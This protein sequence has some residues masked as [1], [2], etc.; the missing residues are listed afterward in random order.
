M[1]IGIIGSGSIARRYIDILKKGFNFEVFVI[2]DQQQDKIMQQEIFG[3]LASESILNE[4]KI[5]I[6]ALIIASENE[7]HISD[8]MTFAKFTNLVL[9]EKPLS[10]LPLRPEELAIFENFQGHLQ[11]SSP[12]RFHKCF[13]ELS[14]R[15]N[16][17]GKVGYIEVICQS[18]LPNWRLGRDFRKG[19]WNDPTQ[20]G[21]LRE[22]IHELDYVQYLF[23]PLRVCWATAT[24]SDILN[25]NVESG[26]TCILESKENEI[27]NLR[28]DFSSHAQRRIFRLD[29]D[30]G[31]IKWDVLKGTLE[32]TNQSVFET[33]SFPSD[34]DRN[35]TFVRQIKAFL[36]HA[37]W[38]VPGT[39]LEDAVNSIKLVEEIYAHIGNFNNSLE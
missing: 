26:V 9:I 31:T 28:L 38:P 7:K 39:N 10:H 35:Q 3:R 27:I 8:F 4:G 30:I 19:F 20:G 11:I 34:Q 5:R 36:D 2:S 17:F 29:G 33:L 15:I 23:G 32:T 25:L 13:V 16:N 18:W 21:V 22:I 1:R 14:E 24:Y 12:L 6:D 37:E